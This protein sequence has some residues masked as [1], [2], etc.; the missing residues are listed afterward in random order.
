MGWLNEFARAFNEKRIVEGGHKAVQ[1]RIWPSPIWASPLRATAYM[2]LPVNLDAFEYID[3]VVFPDKWLYVSYGITLEDKSVYV[4]LVELPEEVN[5]ASDV[6]IA[7][8]TMA[9]WPDI[10]EAARSKFR[11]ACRWYGQIMWGAGGEANPQ[12][13]ELRKFDNLRDAKEALGRC[14]NHLTH[15][16]T[17]S[18]YLLLWAGPVPDVTYPCAGKPDRV[19]RLGPR[20]GARR[21]L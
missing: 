2:I 12:P 20:G 3:L 9:N 18:V 15:N 10:L 11:R 16:G 8:L 14:F 4:P 21:V 13:H 6:A 5:A 1:F 19:Y 17:L 7:A